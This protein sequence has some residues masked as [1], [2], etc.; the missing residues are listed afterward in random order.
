MPKPAAKKRVFISS[1][2]LDMAEERLALKTALAQ[3]C[4]VEFVGMEDWGARSDSPVK[5]CLDEVGRSDL[6]VGI[7]GNRYGHVDYSS[8]QSVTEMEYRH[9]K[10][11]GQPC[12]IFIRS[13]EIASDDER[14]EQFKA[15]LKKNNVVCG[16]SSVSDLAVRVII[17]IHNELKTGRAEATNPTAALIAALFDAPA[18]RRLFTQLGIETSYRG[19]ATTADNANGLLSAIESSGS[20]VALMEALRKAQ[21]SIHWPGEQPQERGRKWLWWG[22]GVG[23]L[24]AAA[25]AGWTFLP[26]PMVDTWRDYFITSEGNWEAVPEK[27]Q[28]EG[29]EWDAPADWRIVRGEAE[30]IDKC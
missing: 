9:A 6:L 18:L 19:E 25:L 10:S 24:C 30:F 12:L 14:F 28:W 8:G 11:R 26:L 16:F 29:S 20:T 3:M 4:D 1:T 23:A 22:V 27:T 7:I 2:S 17:G 15:E 5:V 21:P 13:P